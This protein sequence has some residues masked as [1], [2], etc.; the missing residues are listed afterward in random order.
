MPAVSSTVCRDR[1]SRSQCVVV[2]SGTSDM[3]N[4]PLR[5]PPHPV[6]VLHKQFQSPANCP[7]ARFDNIAM[8][9]I[10]AYIKLA[11]DRRA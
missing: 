4:S 10:K 3:F 8:Y 5:E 1:Q 2:F 6:S 9:L 11:A 7:Y